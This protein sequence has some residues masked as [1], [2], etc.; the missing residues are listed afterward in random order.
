MSGQQEDL[1]ADGPWY[2][3]G[4]RFECTQCGNCCTGAPGYVWMS[5]E[6]IARLAGLLTIP[7]AEFCRRYVRKVRGRQS[8]LEHASGDCVFLDSS[9]RRCRVYQARP[10]QCR[11]WPFWDSNLRSPQAWQATCDVCPGSGRGPLVPLEEIESQRT[12]IRV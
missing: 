10:Q 9:S 2:R 4:L 5:D 11:S 8:L 3:E 6:E 7:I 1:A 12:R